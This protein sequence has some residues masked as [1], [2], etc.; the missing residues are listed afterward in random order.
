MS[1][2]RILHEAFDATVE[3]PKV[4]QSVKRLNE[5]LIAVHAMSDSKK[6]ML[7]DEGFMTLDDLGKWHTT[8]A[9]SDFEK[10]VSQQETILKNVK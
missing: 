4:A 3:A 6:K 5:A 1:R 9:G 2:G 7:S 10:F 8:A